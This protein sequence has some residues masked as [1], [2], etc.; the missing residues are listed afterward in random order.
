MRSGAI[1]A[2][3]ARSLR[4]TE[5]CMATKTY[6]YTI[7]YVDDE[8]GLGADPVDS[9]YDTNG[10]IYMR[11]LGAQPLGAGQTSTYYGTVK[12]SIA[13]IEAKL[14]RDLSFT[15]K[16]AFS[17]YGGNVSPASGGN[18]FTGGVPTIDAFEHIGYGLSDLT[19]KSFGKVHTDT[20]APEIAAIDVIHNDPPNHADTIKATI[21]ADLLGPPDN[22]TDLTGAKSDYP[23]PNDTPGADEPSLRDATQIMLDD[24]SPDAQQLLDADFVMHLV[25]QMAAVADNVIAAGG[26]V[27]SQSYGTD[28]APE[29]TFC[30]G[31]C[32]INSSTGA[33]LLI[34]KGEFSIGGSFAYRGLVLVVGD[35]EFNAGGVASAGLMGGLFVAQTDWDSVNSVWVYDDPEFTLNGNVNFY[36]QLSGIELGFFSLPFKTVSWREINPEIEP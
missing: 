10:T 35:G 2:L 29:I 36:Y 21:Y 27:S 9:Q 20:V 30:V 5:M 22:R 14:K 23:N 34:V 18:L 32:T 6:P 4:Q 7:L 26:T 25:N 15:L 28:A 12:N 16:A 17:L 31:D 3:G 19:S 1:F 24:S 33:G 11:V 8:D 13:I